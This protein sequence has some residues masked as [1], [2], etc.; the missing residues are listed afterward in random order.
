[1]DDIN[2]LRM[3]SGISPAL[4]EFQR[5][6]HMICQDLPRVVVIADNI[7]VCGCGSIEE[8]YRQDHGTN[9]KHLLQRARDT[10]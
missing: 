3:L 5:P 6:M 9:L 10:N 8:E 1:M 4:D 2:I 7:L